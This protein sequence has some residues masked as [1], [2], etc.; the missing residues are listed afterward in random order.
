MSTL[1]IYNFLFSQKDSI[2][3][4]LKPSI[5]TYDRYTVD[6]LRRKQELNVT[7]TSRD[8]LSKSILTDYFNSN[9]KITSEELERLNSTDISEFKSKILSYFNK[10]ITKAINNTSANLSLSQLNESKESAEDYSKFFI[11]STYDAESLTIQQIIDSTS[12]ELNFEALLNSYDESLQNSN[13][14]NESK[15]DLTCFDT[16]LADKAFLDKYQ[17]F[18]NTS[19]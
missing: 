11:R 16:A 4:D 8:D 19:N 15:L 6:S 3:N 9:I 1:N 18:I 13:L 2:L 14:N 17:W 10:N 5:S 7:D 12:T